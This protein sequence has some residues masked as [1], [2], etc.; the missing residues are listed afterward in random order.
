MEVRILDSE[1]QIVESKES[2]QKLY[3]SASN[4]NVFLSYEW[5]TT[6][7]SVFKNCVSVLAVVTV[8]DLDE[9]V[10]LLPL[11]KRAGDRAGVFWFV[12]SG[13]PEAAEVCSEGLDM[14]SARLISTEINQLLK[15]AIDTIGL[16]KLVVSNSTEINQVSMMFEYLGYKNLKEFKGNR[17]F[18]NTGDSKTK[19]EKRTFR[20]L[21][22]AE[23]R[24]ITY[25]VVENVSDLELAFDELKRL[26]NTKW[27]RPGHPSIFDHPLFDA[28]HNSVLQKLLAVEKLSLIAI[29]K[30]EQTIAVNYSMISGDD[31]VFYQ[32]G[33]DTSFK[34]NISPGMLLHCAQLR[35]ARILNLNNYDFLLSM[36]P[37]Y[38][39]DITEYKQ[40]IYS[41]TFHK[42]N[43]TFFVECWRTAIMKAL[44]YLRVRIL[45]RVSW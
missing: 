30:N 21:K 18:I 43:T 1:Q 11:Y 20:Y 6:W 26:H 16:K 25:H 4:S 35:Q 13:E 27:R 45:G 28:F 17:Y 14:L 15:K 31:L 32:S 5:I 9:L 42:Y 19:L 37:S 41:F 39:E 44:S 7:I 29:K 34:P 3:A 36:P 8:W 40:P 22:A 38:K 12:G 2:W 33:V 23:K 24:G 10:C